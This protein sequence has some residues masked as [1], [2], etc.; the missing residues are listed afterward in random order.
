MLPSM[1]LAGS[2]RGA[3]RLARAMVVLFLAAAV[4]LALAPW[5]Q[6]VP[7]NG[8]VIALAPLERQQSIGAPVEGRIVRWHVAEGSRVKLGDLVG[9]IADNDPEILQRLEGERGAV[10]MRLEQGRTRSSALKTRVEQLD[11]FRRNELQVGQNRLSAAEDNVKAATQVVRSAEAS[12]VAAKQ[13]IDRQQMLVK[14]GLVAVRGVELA[15]QD[16]ARAAAEVDRANAALG[17]A[18][19]EKLARES[20]LLKIE[21]DF[22]SRI[23]DARATLA[24]ANS[25]IA[26]AQAEMQRTQVRV[27]RQSRQQILAPRDGTI[28]RLLAQPGSEIL[29]GGD[30]VAL[31]VPE[32]ASLVVE[33]LV[34]GNDVP[35]IHAGDKA[36]L[37][38]EGWPAIQFSG[39]P[40]VAVGTFGGVVTLVDSTD[41]GEGLFRILVQP[42]LDDEPWPEARYLRQG[43]RANGWV[44]LKEVPLGFEIWR[45][46][47]GFPPTINPKPEAD[48]K[49]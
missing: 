47:N 40:S 36:R 5:V 45:Q 24:S 27:S 20:D 15:Q 33:L 29:K 35:L 39:W 11:L 12:L 1:A 48:G 41:N 3:R 17:G 32:S 42:D 8:R 34:N 28:L 22:R 31:F 23:E 16:Y 18:V 13:N 6:N 37:Q 38:F 46:F 7:G 44:L 43:V 2:T 9:E 19:N 26:N 10:Q 30:P 14:K 49:P 25:E 4:G 21:S